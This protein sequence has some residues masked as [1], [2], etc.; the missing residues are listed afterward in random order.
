MGRL[1]GRQNHEAGRRWDRALIT[2]ASSGIGEAFARRLA[3]DGTDLVLV[4]RRTERL[5]QLGAELANRAK[6]V[7]VEVVTADLGS[8]DDLERVAARLGDEAEAD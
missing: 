5:E 3:A 2:G 6:P 4:A 8:G 1:S 7:D